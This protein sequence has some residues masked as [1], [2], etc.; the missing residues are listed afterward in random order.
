MSEKERKKLKFYLFLIGCVLIF[1]F[2][3]DYSLFDTLFLIV[4]LTI[5]GWGFIKK[6]QEK[7]T[8]K[9]K[10][11]LTLEHAN[12]NH[13]QVYSWMIG[14]GSILLNIYW[15]Y[16]DSLFGWNNLLI[17]LITLFIFLNGVLFPKSVFVWKENHLLFIKNR[18]TT[19]EF[20]LVDFDFFIK[21]TTITGISKDKNENKK[22]VVR[23]LEL[24][25]KDEFNFHQ[26]QKQQN[27][28]ISITFDL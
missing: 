18:T 5:S 11:A 2:L 28:D 17:F 13:R 26:W 4:V 21:R 6:F 23:D 19:F 12:D 8:F 24:K 14:G 3:K 22:Q 10:K 25:A 7:E 16:T 9:K 27:I 15:F 20:A 1:F